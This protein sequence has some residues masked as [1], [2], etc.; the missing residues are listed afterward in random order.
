MAHSKTAALASSQELADKIG[1]AIGAPQGVMVCKS[2]VSTTGCL[3]DAKEVNPPSRPRG[4]RHQ[5][6]GLILLG[7]TPRRLKGVGR[8]AKEGHASRG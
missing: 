2:L 1:Q 4:Q 5:P 8:E 6:V 7:A 3:G